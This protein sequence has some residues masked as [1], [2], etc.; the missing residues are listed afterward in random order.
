MGALFM[1]L[2]EAAVD[3]GEAENLARAILDVFKQRKFK[4]SPEL[5]AWGNFSMA[6][7]TV[8]LPR[9]IVFLAKRRE[10]RDAKRQEH[11]ATASASEAP[12]QAVN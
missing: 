4:P 1:G 3:D 12:A 8:Y 5:L 10:A 7:A 9:L 11:F 2:P 6:V